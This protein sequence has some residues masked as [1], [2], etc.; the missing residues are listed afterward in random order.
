MT[1]TIIQTYLTNYPA[2]PGAGVFYV[3]E[4]IVNPVDTSIFGIYGVFTSLPVSLTLGTNVFTV[5]SEFNGGLTLTSGDEIT[6]LF[7]MHDA[8]NNVPVISN[9]STSFTV[10]LAPSCFTHGSLILTPTG[11]MPVENLSSGQ[12]VITHDGRIVPIT[13]IHKSSFTGTPETAP[14]LVPKNSLNIG[15]PVNDLRLSPHHSIRDTHIMR[16]ITPHRAQSI[17]PLIVQ[18]GLKEKIDYIHIEMPNY[19]TDHLICD[20]TVV[21]SFHSN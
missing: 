15:T 12:T 5:G 7:C 8:L 19:L 9:E 6:A 2:N 10:I 20:G 16:W 14:F 4:L 13:R 17:N 11:N 3:L 21:E 18:Y 1:D